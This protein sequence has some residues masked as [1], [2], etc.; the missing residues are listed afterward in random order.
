[1]DTIESIS[2]QVTLL[3]REFNII[4]V[5]DVPADEYESYTPEIIQDF[6]LR[7]TVRPYLAKLCD[8]ILGILPEE[9]KLLYK[10]YI[11][12]SDKIDALLKAY[13]EG[14]N[15][16]P[17][18]LHAVPYPSNIHFC[19]DYDY[20]WHHYRPLFERI[21]LFDSES[22]IGHSLNLFLFALLTDRSKSDEQW[23]PAALHD[24]GT[25]SSIE[26]WLLDERPATPRVLRV[27]CWLVMEVEFGTCIGDFISPAFYQYLYSDYL[28]ELRQ[29]VLDER[30]SIFL[31]NF[32]IVFAGCAFGSIKELNDYSYL[33]TEIRQTFHMMHPIFYPNYINWP[34]D[35]MGKEV[36]FKAMHLQFRQNHKDEIQALKVASQPQQI[37]LWGRFLYIMGLK[38]KDQKLTQTNTKI[39]L[40]KGSR[41]HYPDNYNFD[42][43]F[44]NRLKTQAQL[45]G[46]GMKVLDYLLWMSTCY[47]DSTYP[48]YDQFVTWLR[49]H[50]FEFEGDDP[51]GLRHLI[52]GWRPESTYSINLP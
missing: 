6:R 47:Y 8:Y 22:Y 23:V 44:F 9:N 39:A 48:Q 27:T 4:D 21:D 42:P 16:R 2:K 38:I 3:V 36:D 15:P 49:D 1:M 18:R 26:E 51:L 32:V 43:L 35:Y 30:K 5:E 31:R 52:S 7:G 46:P 45:L 28:K 10:D 33:I 11:I 20:V 41:K 24:L 17:K 14:D 13:F 40:S 25:T 19:T 50:G 12:Y 37:G 29:F 34:D